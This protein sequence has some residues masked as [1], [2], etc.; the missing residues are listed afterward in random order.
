[1]YWGSYAGIGYGNERAKMHNNKSRTIIFLF[2]SLLFLIIWVSDSV[3]GAGDPGERG[4]CAVGSQE[5]EIAGVAATVFY[6]STAVCSDFAQEPFAAI[7]FAHG[8]SMFGLSNGVSENE[9]N[10]EHLASWGYVVAI[11][12]LPDDAEERV[13]LLLN[14]LDFLESANTDSSSFLYEKVDINRLTTAGH[15]L[16]GA[17]ALATAARDNRIT[18]V[19][20]LDPVYHAGDFSGEGEI[21]WD[22][23]KEAPRITV[24]TGI[25]GAPPSSCNAEADYAEIYPLVGSTHKAAY[26]INSASHCVFADPGSSFCSL[27]CGGD[28]KPEMTAASKKY[29]TAWFNYYVQLKP[30]YFNYIYGDQAQVD[31]D[32]GLINLTE[33]TITNNLTAS[34]FL[35]A[36]EL[37]WDRYNQ[38]ILAGYKIYRRLAE[39]QSFGSP[40]AS[41][42]LTESFIDFAVTSGQEYSYAVRSFDTAGNFHQLSKEVKIQVEP[43]TVEAKK[44]YLPLTLGP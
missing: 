33:D 43:E 39:E 7:A 11:P 17:T 31:M 38:P 2:S 1:M 42:D 14:V 25:L 28:T 20:A 26:L 9:A 5:I 13:G 3:K 10:G 8:F 30:E 29:M 15:S 41:V 23:V 24:P 37:Q 22:A 27:F 12:E 44:N 16:G 19:V 36:V 34:K 32:A 18:A 35:N 21:I 6:P 40:L 4:P